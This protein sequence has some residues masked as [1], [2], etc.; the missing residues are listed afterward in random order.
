[1]QIAGGALVAIALIKPQLSWLILLFCLLSALRRGLWLMLA[2]AA[3]SFGLMFTASLV[4]VPGWIPA[5]LAQSR[6]YSG[7]IPPEPL[8]ATYAR[9]FLPLST[10]K[11]VTYVWISIALLLTLFLLWQWFRLPRQ[12]GYSLQDWRLLSWL[13]LTTYL[14]HPWPKSYEQLSIIVPFFLWAS[15]SLHSHKLVPSLFWLAGLVVSWWALVDDQLNLTPVGIYTWPVLFFIGWQIY[16]WLSDP[17]TE[18]IALN[19]TS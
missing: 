2:G 4:F 13:G 7:Y 3:V 8:M 1:M 5:W 15:S 12:E 18:R 19:G 9:L 16:A 17:T 14:V 10:A 11:I 6:A